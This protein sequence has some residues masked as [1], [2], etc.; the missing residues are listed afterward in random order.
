MAFKCSLIF[1]VVLAAFGIVAA[2]MSAQNRTAANYT[3]RT[4]PLPDNGT[5]DVSMA[6]S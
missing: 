6:N 1:G 5:G 3:V 2:T 4:L